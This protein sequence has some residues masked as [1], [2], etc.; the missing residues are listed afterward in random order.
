MTSAIVT[1]SLTLAL[2]SFGLGHELDAP[3]SS[4]PQGVYIVPPGPG[5]GWGFPNDNPDHYGWVDY[6]V[7]LPLGADRTAEYYFPRY[8]AVSSGADVHPDVLQLLRDAGP[9]VH[10]LRRRGRR[11]SRWAG[12]RRH[13]RTCRFL[14]TRPTPETFPWYRCLV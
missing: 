10:S 5:D 11:P 7:Y 13:R 2:S 1:M 6:G 12:R 3:S 14:P 4:V 8:F 9:A